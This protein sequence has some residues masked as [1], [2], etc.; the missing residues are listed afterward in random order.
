MEMSEFRPIVVA[1][2]KQAGIANSQSIISGN[3]FSIHGCLAW[4]Q[5]LEHTDSCRVIL[6]LGQPEGGIPSSLLRMMLEFNCANDSR[7]LPTL[8]INPKNGNTLL[9]LHPPIAVLHTGTSL[10]DLLDVQLKPVV[11]A[12][13]RCFD[14][15]KNETVEVSVLPDRG[16]V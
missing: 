4:L 10:F 15:V 5:Y 16:F 6:E 3:A 9:M 14:A 11:D 1:F 7:Y 13:V 12:W 8:G 2:C